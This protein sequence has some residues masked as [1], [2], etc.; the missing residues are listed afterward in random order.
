MSEVDI[1]KD[2]FVEYSEFIIAS[3]SKKKLLSKNNLNEA[4]N[5][6]D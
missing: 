4:F 6:F 1:N 5:A 2:G 3:M